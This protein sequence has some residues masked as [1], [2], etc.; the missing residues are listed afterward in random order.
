[1]CSAKLI[2][3]HRAAQGFQYT[4]DDDFIGW[5]CQDVATLVAGSA[6][7]KS[8]HAKHTREFGY[9]MWRDALCFAQL[10]NAHSFSRSAGSDANEDSQTIFFLC[11]YFHIAVYIDQSIMT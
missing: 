7:D 10:R 3:E 2:V 11:G 4:P 6:V 8:F 1:M 5:L 9:I